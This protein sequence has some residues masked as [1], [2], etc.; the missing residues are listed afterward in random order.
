MSAIAIGGIIASYKPSYGLW[1]QLQSGESIDLMQTFAYSKILRGIGPIIIWALAF[2]FVK[3]FAKTSPEI[4][5]PTILLLIAT[6]LRIIQFMLYKQD[7]HL[8]FDLDKQTVIAKSNKSSIVEH[9]KL[10][11]GKAI[12]SLK[13]VFK[14]HCQ[15]ALYYIYGSI[16][17]L[18][19]VTY[20]LGEISRVS[21]YQ[22]QDRSTVIMLGMLAGLLVQL[23]YSFIG[24]KYYPVLLNWAKLRLF[25]A[26]AMI[27]SILCSVVFVYRDDFFSILALSIIAL[28]FQL[29]GVGIVRY[30]STSFMRIS[31]TET[32]SIFFAV[33]ETLSSVL[34]LIVMLI[35]AMF[36]N[37][38][39][40]ICLMVILFAI[41]GAK[42]FWGARGLD[43]SGLSESG[44]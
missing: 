22:G 33:A 14:N 28:M 31:K 41:V 10:G 27:T 39:M 11:I 15:Y 21:M 30:I 16:F 2:V 5:I 25:C 12:F 1:Y 7:L 26:I 38:A 19:M 43:N 35:L 44:K 23:L 9:I 29:I 8:I 18:I 37:H 24:A 40:G 36:D 3:A 20:L 13:L 34:W 4:S 6:A 32:Q 17:F 42:F